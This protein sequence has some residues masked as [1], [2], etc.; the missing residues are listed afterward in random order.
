[1]KYKK[2]EKLTKNDLKSLKMVKKRP[3]MIKITEKKSKI[4]YFSFYKKRVFVSINYHSFIKKIIIMSPFI[5]LK[6]Q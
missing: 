4:E 3:K 1:M 2:I 5:K 6:G